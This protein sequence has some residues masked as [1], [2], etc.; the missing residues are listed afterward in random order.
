[1]PPIAEAPPP[2]GSAVL[3]FHVARRSFSMPPTITLE[4][5]KGFRVFVLNAVFRRRDDAPDLANAILFR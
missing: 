2:D 5:I 1:M 4:Q 3:E